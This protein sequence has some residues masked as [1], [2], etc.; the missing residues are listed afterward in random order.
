[1]DVCCGTGTVG[2]ILAKSVRKVI[3]IEMSSYLFY[4]QVDLRSSCSVCFPG[5]DAIQDA[6]ENASMNNLNNIQ[7]HCGKAE[8]ILPL[9]GSY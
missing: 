5:E 4:S 8:Q 9:L 3:G 1:M 7:Y 6:K 2:I